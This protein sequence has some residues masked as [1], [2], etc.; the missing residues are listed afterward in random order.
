[1]IQ[2]ICTV[3]DT[4]AEMFEPPFYSRSE[5]EAERIFSD[6]VNQADSR[7]GK[8]PEDYQLFLLGTFETDTAEI[9]QLGTRKLLGS[10]VKYLTS[11]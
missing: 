7:V 1:M 10:G 6:A 5:L 11:E 2:F 9:T 8:H 4:K 3:Y